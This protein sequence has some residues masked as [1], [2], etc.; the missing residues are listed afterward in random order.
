MGYPRRAGH[1]APRSAYQQRSRC[2]PGAVPQ[3]RCLPASLRRG[4]ARSPALRRTNVSPRRK[5]GSRS[6]QPPNPPPPLTR[7]FFDGQRKEPARGARPR[8]RTAR[9]ARRRGGSA[10]QD[11]SRVPG[12][13]L[14]RERRGHARHEAGADRVALADGD[15]GSV[16]D[17]RGQAGDRRRRPVELPGRRAAH[18][19]LRLHAERRGDR[20][21]QTRP[22]RRVRRHQ[23]RRGGARQAPHPRPA[24]AGG[25]EPG[26]GVRAD[27]PA[28]ERDRPREPRRTPSPRSCR[29]RS[30]R[31]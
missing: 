12:H 14:G 11:R 24:G 18:E 3:L 28:R 25:A 10:H 16:R 5:G 17:R 27:P 21:V 29:S 7:R 20:R 8:A 13:A 2:E 9:H 4:R 30:R 19:A 26:R 22:G 15:R 1:I 23:G 31:S 6:R